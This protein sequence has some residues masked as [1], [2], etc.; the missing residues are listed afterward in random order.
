MNIE[1]CTVQ[2]NYM[3]MYGCEFLFARLAKIHQSFRVVLLFAMPVFIVQYV[4][5]ANLRKQD[6]PRNSSFYLSRWE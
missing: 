1:E 5:M 3:Y 6:V 4:A 2:H